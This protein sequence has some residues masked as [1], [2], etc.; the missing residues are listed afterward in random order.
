MNFLVLCNT[1]AENSEQY[2]ME[3]Y[4]QCFMATNNT[5][6]YS[7]TIH[8]YKSDKHEQN[9]GHLSHISLDVSIKIK[10]RKY[11]HKKIKI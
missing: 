1:L 10:Q 2:L 8:C 3:F 5:I 4:T 7:D 6:S 11:R 9:S